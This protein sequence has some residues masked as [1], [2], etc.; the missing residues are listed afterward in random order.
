MGAFIPIDWL[1]NR[2]KGAVR[3][4]GAIPNV[5]VIDMNPVIC[6]IGAAL[7]E[8]NHFQSMGSWCKV[9]IDQAAGR[10]VAAVGINHALTDPVDKDF[11][12]P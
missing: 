6:R 3:H 4:S 10:V 12:Q 5:D 7:I 11:G 9:V 8:N 1:Q 2:I